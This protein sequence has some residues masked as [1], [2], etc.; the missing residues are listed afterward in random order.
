MAEI[1]DEIVFLKGATYMKHPNI[2]SV[3]IS[4]PLLY[5]LLA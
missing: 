3:L 1:F 4:S 5:G 2:N